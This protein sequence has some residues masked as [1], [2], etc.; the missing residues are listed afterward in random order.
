MFNNEVELLEIRLNELNPVVDE[1]H[2]YESMEYHGST[3]R[4]KR[5]VFE[6]DFD[7]WGF[8][9]KVRYFVVDRLVP[10]Y[11]NS[12]C[13][14]PREN[15]HRGLLLSSISEDPFVIMSDVDEIPRASV[16]AQVKTARELFSLQVDMF[17]YNVNNWT[18]KWNGPIVGRSSRFRQEGGPQAVRNR[19]DSLPRVNDA[20]WHFSY[21]G[22][23]D[24]VRNKVENFAHSQDWY[25]QDLMKRPVV[26]LENDMRRRH[27]LFRRSDGPN[28]EGKWASDDQRLPRYFLDNREKFRNLT[29]DMWTTPTSY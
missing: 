10:E 8:R 11:T 27:D 16:I 13:T 2:I 29:E 7:F 15:Y 4:K 17:Y 14:W 9:D 25:C 1:F 24:R 18:C 21:F 23:V 28:R 19:R 5:S 6:P 3:N 26:E 20:G 22:G 12:H